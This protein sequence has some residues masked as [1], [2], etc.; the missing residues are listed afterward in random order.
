MPA[1]NTPSSPRTVE[2]LL[3]GF[4]PDPAHSAPLTAQKA[5]YIARCLQDRAAALQTPQERRQQAE[6]DRMMSQPRDKATVVEM[7][8]QAFRPADAGRTASQLTHILDVQGVPRFFSPLERT[9]LRGFQSFGSYLPG[10]AVPLV[11]EKMREETANVVVPAEPEHLTRFLRARR[12]AG[13]RMNVNFLGEAMLGEEEAE[14]RLA[15]YLEALQLPELEVLSVKVSTVYSQLSSLAIEHTVEVLCDR[16]E[17]LY[18]AA[19]RARF[20]RADGRTVPKFVYLDMEE[21]RDL[22][23]TSRAFMT[24]LD[25]P[26][27]EGVEAGIALQA[28]LPDSYA[29]QQRLAA[30]AGRRV[31]GGG[32]PVTLR[33][34]K[35][36]NGEMERVDASIHGWPQAPYPTKVEVDANFKRMLH[37]ALEPDNIAALRLGIASHN[38]FD[39]AYSIVLAAERDVLDRVQLEMLEGMANHQ[40][41][42]LLEIVENLLLYSPATRKQDFVHAIG[43]LIRRLDENT[44]PDNFLRHAYKLHTDAPEWRALERDFYRSFEALDGL[45]STPRRT[46][47]RRRDADGPQ[48]VVAARGGLTTFRSEADTD[49]AL[50][51]NVQWAREIIRKWEPL[52]GD[53]ALDIPLV[54][55]GEEILDGREIRTCAD[56]SRLGTVVGRYRLGT[57]T[58]VEGALACARRDPDGWRQL[59]AAERAE[60]LSRV[61]QC[62]RQARA[63]LMGAAMADG[64]KIL[65]ESDPEVSEAVDF[66]EFYGRSVVDLDEMPELQ[67]RGRGVVV[68]VSPWN[69]PIAIPCGGIA[70]ALAAGNTV[71]LKPASDAVLVAHEL[72]RCFWRAGVSKRALQ[73]LPCHGG[74]IGAQLVSSPDVDAVVLTGGTDTALTMLEETPGLRLFGETGGKNATVVTALADR[75]QA[76]KHVLHSAF[77]HAGQKCSATSLLILEAE[78]YDDEGFRRTL[79]DAVSSLQVGPAWDRATRVGPLIRPPSGDLERGLTKLEEGE[80][81][82]VTPRRDAD[83]PH[84]WTPGVKWDV[85]PGSFTHC[86]EFFGPLLAVMRARHLD[87]A[88]SLVNQ[89]GFGLTS[90]LESLDDREQRIWRGG[91]AAGNLYMNRVTTGAVVLRQPFGGQGKSSFGAG[92][93]AGGPNYVAQLMEIADR[94]EPESSPSVR[95]P[96]LDSLC[97]GLEAHLASPGPL[98]ATQARRSLVAV[99]SYDLWMRREFGLEHD[100][101]R[102]V[103]Q[104]N[105]RRYLPLVDVRLRVDEDDSDFD[106][107]ARVAAARAVGSRPIVSAAPG[108]QL[109]L[110]ETVQYLTERWA[111]AIEFVE[112]DDDELIGQIDAGQID[113]LRYA[114]PDRVPD[115]VLR[116]AARP[117][118]HVASEPV[119]ASGRIELLWYLRE[120]SVSFDYHRY[121][122][123]GARS[124]EVRAEV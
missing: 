120:Q 99:R 79:H 39:L 66:L 58:D 11:R 34:V 102:L 94:D 53:L 117:G 9:L 12:A 119:L 5:V 10:V 70:A 52:Q 8:D 15:R 18:R 6:L 87:E 109:Q 107:I 31:A 46:Q 60:T 80:T 22:E 38:L 110:L 91:I 121:G 105:T 92:M 115:R 63:D 49:F 32:A 30:W 123:L 1:R 54:V 2:N 122:N 124:G 88:I 72:C 82:G 59:L 76:I 40:R 86:T 33:L 28:Y 42:A 19:A 62:V 35:G 93:K 89:T 90:G 43:Y 64:G 13:L 84:L 4:S 108:V 81:W 47:D 98:D 51:Q 111:A 101:F 44:G 57:S 41:R 100:H 116:A 68:V 118:V 3:A 55:D 67:T 65:S 21:Y 25:R 16:L 23:I 27:L 36:A 106:L 74:T 29:V 73:F 69:F 83:N 85:R 56:P 24:T 97:A 113:R 104:D 26:G 7:T 96:L 75:D 103:G 17:L 112:E 71:I 61:A 14:A 78:V 95:D 37:H 50:G 114:H 45:A 48:P 77:S 20:E